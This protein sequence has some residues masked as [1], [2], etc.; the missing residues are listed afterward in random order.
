MSGQSIIEVESDKASMEIA[1][2][3]TGFVT[4]ILVELGENISTG[5]KVMIL[6]SGNHI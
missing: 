2:L 6:D 3:A 1:S 5:S 4:D